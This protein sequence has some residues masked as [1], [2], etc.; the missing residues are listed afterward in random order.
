MKLSDTQLV[1]LQRG[2][3]DALGLCRADAKLPQ[4]PRIAIAK[5]LLAAGLVEAEPWRPFE[6]PERRFGD[7]VLR[8]TD[9]GLRAI[10][11]EPPEEE[12]IPPHDSEEERAMQ[13][14]A[15]VERDIEAAEETA[16]AEAVA[17]APRAADPAT[18]GI[19]AARAEAK[20]RAEHRA[21]RGFWR[22]AEEA[23]SRGE[24]PPAPDF[25][26]PT[27]APYRKKLEKLLALAQA[28]DAAGLRAVAINPT[29]TSPKTLIR[30]RDLALRAIEA[31]TFKKAGR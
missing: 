30:W 11:I 6:A 23:A 7:H 14:A 22:A 24:L 15:I 31:R 12:P 28:G 17:N 5:K 9:A 20:A 19:L 29:S 3:D 16:A 27:H 18:D 21:G 2:A 4:A 8:I 25:S 13:R 10:G 1:I 26:A